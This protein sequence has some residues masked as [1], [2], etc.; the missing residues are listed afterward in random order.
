MSL[1]TIADLHLSTLDTTNKSMEVFGKRW[2]NYM[3]RI[4]LNWKKLVTENDTVVIPGDISWALSLEE[5]T[6]DLKLLDSLPGT[7]YIGKGNHDFWWSTASKMNAVFEKLNIKTIKLLYNNAYV[8]E[9]FVVCGSRGWFTD[10]SQQNVV[11]E[12]DYAKIV[13]REAT[14]LKISL[15][16]GRKLKKETGFPII[17]FLHFPPL[18]NDFACEEILALLKEYNVKKCFFGHIHGTYNIPRKFSFDG[19]EMIL[20]SADFLNFCAIPVFSDFLC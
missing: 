9:N 13:N 4:E 8:I 17:V 11:G 19:I 20:T 3:E 14:R 5:A 1:F 2:D 12:V 6:S 7:K 15:E 18:W 10:R 16:E